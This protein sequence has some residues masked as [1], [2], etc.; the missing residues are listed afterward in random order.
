MAQE[1]IKTYYDSG[2][3][4]GTHRPLYIVGN[5]FYPHIYAT[6]NKSMAYNTVENLL[7]S[8]GYELYIYHMPMEQ[9]RQ[10]TLEVIEIYIWDLDKNCYIKKTN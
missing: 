3:Y 4:D 10:Y 5:S 9:I 7:I 8:Y 6:H 2:V 1:L